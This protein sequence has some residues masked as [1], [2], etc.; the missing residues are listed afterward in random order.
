MPRLMT[1]AAVL[2]V[3]TAAAFAH[4]HDGSA[5][6][7][8]LPVE[9][10]ENGGMI[11]TLPGPGPD[12]T[13]L[14]VI[15]AMRL[16]SGLGSNP[17]GL[18]RGWGTS[19]VIVRFRVAGG[20]VTAEVENQSYR[21]SSDNPDERRAVEE[22][23]ARSVI[24]SGDVIE[25]TDGSVTF[26]IGPL[27]MADLLGLADRLEEDG[28][29][30]FSLEKDRSRVAPD[31]ILTF[32]LNTEIDTE[33]TFTS[34]DPGPEV[35]QTAPYPGA[36]TMT[37]HHSFVALP[38]EGYETRD[39]DPRV[40]TFDLPFYDFSAPLDEPVRRTFAM[41]HRLSADEPIIFHVDR[42]APEPV[43]SA[44]VE[45]ASW[46]AEGFA[47]AGYP[48]GYRVEV[49]PEGVH[50][51]DARYNVIQWVHRQTRGWSYGGG[52]A[53]PRTGEFVKGHVILGS[54]RVRQDRMIF[55]GLAGTANTG[56]GEADDP[57]ELA[58][59]RI[60]QLSAHEVGH[61]LGFGHNFAASAND[62][63]SVMD[64]PAPWVIAKDG[65]LDFSRTYDAGLGDWDRLTVRW[66][67]GEESGDAVV[68]EAR[69]RGL[70]FVEDAEG[71]GVDTAHPLA[72]V[73][74]NGADPVD[75]LANVMEVRRIALEAFGPDRLAEGLPRGMLHEVLVPI[76]LY[77]RYQT[78]AAAKPIGGASYQYAKS[79]QDEGRVVIVPAKEQMRAL[80]AVL[81]TVTPEALDIPDRVLEILTP[82]ADPFQRPGMRESVAAETGPLFDLVSA[83][84]NAADISFASLLAPAR[85][86][87]IA[88]FEARNEDAP[89]LDD[90]LERIVSSVTEGPRRGS[91]QETLAA[92]AEG[93]LVAHLIAADRS[94]ASLPVQGELRDVLT[95]LRDSFAEDDGYRGALASQITAHLER[96]APP[97]APEPIAPR[98]PPG[99]PIGGSCW[100]CR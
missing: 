52:V 44:L 72:S 24:F 75:E 84:E 14:R 5:E 77:H 69:E 85:L 36:V 37:V 65:E 99:S 96:N 17:I 31:G 87:R 28:S 74:D 12:G 97:V 82:R 9:R 35:R 71:R 78:A 10:G 76:Y 67:Y 29:G 92:A 2:L 26:D 41:R 88:Q 39:Y 93:R 49:L 1:L 89:S 6:P 15:H 34:S 4:P 61:A 18:D 30:S 47:A 59:A 20:R 32:P 73:W 11:A 13:A 62:R 40:G 33:L 46:W 55:E 3:L 42:G 56:S 63:A 53:D 50:P 21:A 22:S 86:E 19:G 25:E 57:V 70:L 64:Y 90:V 16:T 83:A 48:G 23:F 81:R 80:D 94:S 54:Q 38:E 100:P 58:L 27:L 8:L 68:A 45:G 7:K 91:R 98:V 79:G 95:A 51:L 60:R 66:L 43:R